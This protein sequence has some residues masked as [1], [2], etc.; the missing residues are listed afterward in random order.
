MMPSATYVRDRCVTGVH[1]LDEILRGG[2]PFG[3]TVLASGTCGSGKT[4][5]GLEFLV[6]GALAGEA[7][8]H[9]TATEPSVKVLEN[10]RQFPFFDMTMVDIGGV[11]LDA[12]K[13][14]LNADVVGDLP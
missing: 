12:H 6:R 8:A 14:N 10:V 1:G 9:F 5:L 2:I 4:T 11:D 7:C 13:A 3:S